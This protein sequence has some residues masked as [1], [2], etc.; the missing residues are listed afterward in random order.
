MTEKLH[1]TIDII[2]FTKNIFVKHNAC[3]NIFSKGYIRTSL[4]IDFGLF[5]PLCT[6][7]YVEHLFITF[8][9]DQ[10]KIKK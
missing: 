3:V 5:A 7:I 2:S 6:F 1:K 10:V 4:Y 8:F 9:L